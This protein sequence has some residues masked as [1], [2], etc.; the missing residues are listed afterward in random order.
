VKN[1]VAKAEQV[2][3]PDAIAKDLRKSIVLKEEDGLQINE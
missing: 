2:T 3:D 1:T